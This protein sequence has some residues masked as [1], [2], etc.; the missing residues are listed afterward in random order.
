M[1]PEI[2]VVV[3]VYNGGTALALCL[4]ALL[5]STH[6]RFEVIVVDDASTDASAA[7]AAERGVRVISQPKR[8][9]PSVARNTGAAQAQGALLVL[10]DAD[11]VVPPTALSQAAAF[12][13]EH[14]EVAG[15]SAIYASQCRV[16][17]FGSQYLVL[18]QRYFQ[19]QVP[20]MTD[21]TWTAFFAVRRQAFLDCGG[22]DIDMHHPAADDLVLGSRLT[23]A[24]HTLAFCHDIE[25]E[26]LKE[27][28]VAGTWRF[29]HVHAREWSRASRRY[30]LLLPQ[31]LS[32]SRR[33]VGNTILAVGI[34]GLLLMGPLGVVLLPIPCAVATAWNA[35]F[36]RWMAKQR[37]WS[38]AAAALPVTLVEGLC[39][40]TGL[41]SAIRKP[42]L[43]SDRSTP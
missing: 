40:V 43:S 23:M 33:P 3:P 39:N 5:A 42:P 29:H 11:V 10:L 30:R 15:L 14:P 32:H 19:L 16:Q 13:A 36:I 18:K 31:K 21:T 17:G 35:H 27:I 22:L 8:S 1:S 25:V 20:P 2:S 12:L 24:G 38:F 41:I 9:G 4:D 37:T 34:G 28:S 26:H 6:P 7:V